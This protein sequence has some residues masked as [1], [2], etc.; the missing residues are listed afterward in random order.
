MPYTVPGTEYPTG[1]SDTSGYWK[2]SGTGTGR[3]ASQAVHQYP[4]GYQI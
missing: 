3:L 4:I 1:W 2:A